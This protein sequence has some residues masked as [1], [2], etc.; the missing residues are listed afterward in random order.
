MAAQKSLLLDH[1]HLGHIGLEHVQS[2][3]CC[4]TATSTSIVESNC[5]PC[6]IPCHPQVLSCSAPVC[7]A[8]SVAKAR[9]LPRA[10]GCTSHATE[11]EQHSLSQNVLHPGQ[12]IFTDQY[13]SSVRG[14]LATTQGLKSPTQQYCGGTLFFD[15]ASQF[16]FVQHQVSLGAT[17]TLMSKSQ[18]EHEATQCGITINS[19]HT[20]NG[21]FTK[22]Q[23]C[24]A[25][26]ATNQGHTVS[27]MGAHHQNGLAEHAIKTIQDMM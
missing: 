2:L 11:G 5:T 8:C 7:L 3:Y 26:L 15:V 19:Y 16:I 27:G 24:N 17:N 6:I 13:K 23:F 21:I 1:Q 9:K 20:D 4:V 10:T 12:R 14:C 22:S 18:F 25:L